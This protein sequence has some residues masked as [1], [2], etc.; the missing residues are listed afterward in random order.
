MV[1]NTYSKELLLMIVK[2]VGD[3]GTYREGA[4]D[5]YGTQGTY[6]TLHVMFLSIV[7]S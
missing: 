3:V 5:V 1:D 4:G 7:S 6:T 2:K